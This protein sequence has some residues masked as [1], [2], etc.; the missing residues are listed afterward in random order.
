MIGGS[1]SGLALLGLALAGM[2]AGSLSFSSAASRHRNVVVCFNKKTGGVFRAPVLR[3]T[4]HKCT[5]TKR[6]QNPDNA[7]SVAVTDLH[8][9][10]WGHNRAFGTGK[11]AENT[12]GLVP[13]KVKLHRALN[14]CGGRRVFSKARFEFPGTSGGYGR[15][16]PLDTCP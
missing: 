7:D 2:T 5:F 1:V 6:G 10:R 15:P 16:M 13:V 4:P 9:K 12:I 11:A 3:T 8:W 14:R